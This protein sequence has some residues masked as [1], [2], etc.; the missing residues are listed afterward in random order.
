MSFGVFLLTLI[1]LSY[2]W[3]VYAP[4]SSVGL[5]LCVF[6]RRYLRTNF[7]TR[8]VWISFAM[9]SLLAP[10]LIGIGHNIGLLLPLP[11]AVFCVHYFNYGELAWN[12]LYSFFVILIGSILS[13][14]RSAYRESQNL[15][16]VGRVDQWWRAEPR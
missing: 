14:R 12:P 2:S 15:S 9:A 11:F 7:W 8:V 13:A 6:L 1:A 16:I 4:L 10:V 3:I 5:Y